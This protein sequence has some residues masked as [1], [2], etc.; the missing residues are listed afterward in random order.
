MAC[1]SPL[2]SRPDRDPHPTNPVASGFRATIGYYIVL[3]AHS[4]MS[5]IIYRMIALSVTTYTDCQALFVFIQW[6][7]NTTI[8]A[9]SS[10]LLVRTIAVW[11]RSPYVIAPMLLLA[12]G[13]WGLLYY[14]QWNIH[15]FLPLT[16]S[17]THSHQVSP[18]YVITPSVD[19]PPY[20]KSRPSHH[21]PSRSRRNGLPNTPSAS[22][23]AHPLP[24][25]SHYT[26]TVSTS[27]LTKY[28]FLINRS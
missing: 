14:S 1:K 15:P 10:L 28:P 27:L 26:C 3:T 8:G 23:L 4:F 21:P 9:S 6:A 7:G 18:R 5:H 12:L 16:H 11:N 22:S 17:F 2:W 24:F 20:S 13:Q 19:T 25:S